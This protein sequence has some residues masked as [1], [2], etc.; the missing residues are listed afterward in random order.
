MEREDK[1]KKENAG[2]YLRNHE[3]NYLNRQARI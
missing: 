2:M 1:K 3:E